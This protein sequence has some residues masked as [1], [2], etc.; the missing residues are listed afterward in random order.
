MRTCI[1]ICCV[2][3]GNTQISL[4]LLCSVTIASPFMLYLGEGSEQNPLSLFF[5]WVGSQY[6]RMYCV[7]MC[8][9]G[10]QP[11][12]ED[13]TREANGC[14]EMSGVELCKDFFLPFPYVLLSSIKYSH[15][16]KQPVWSCFMFAFC[17]SHCS[18]LIVLPL[19]LSL[20]FSHS[21][22]LFPS[23]E[24]AGR[25]PGQK[26]LSSPC[27]QPCVWDRPVSWQQ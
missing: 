20:V 5:Q 1:C 22:S 14:Q 3:G 2:V 26:E 18:W 7:G 11:A 25:V 4:K 17:W 10:L 6:G 13:E 12:K 15:G 9:P 19:N 23:L 27:Q 16:N 21:L 8:S 24:N